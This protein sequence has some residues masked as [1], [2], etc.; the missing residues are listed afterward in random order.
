[1]L[2]KKI[3]AELITVC[4]CT[5][6][7]QSEIKPRILLKHVFTLSHSKERLEKK[8]FREGKIQDYSLHVTSWELRSHSDSTAQA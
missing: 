2:L 5:A 1:M 4:Q 8:Q 7:D 3:L 6:T